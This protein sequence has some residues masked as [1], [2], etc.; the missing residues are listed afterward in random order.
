VKVGTL[1][2]VLACGAFSVLWTIWYLFGHLTGRA[3]HLKGRARSAYQWQL[4]GYKAERRGKLREAADAY[5]EALRLDPTNHDLEARHARLLE[6]LADRD[7]GGP[8]A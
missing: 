1:V 7:A 2:L 4:R 3:G 6:V 8:D 5:A